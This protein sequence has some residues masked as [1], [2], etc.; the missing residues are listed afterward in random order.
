[1]GEEGGTSLKEVSMRVFITGGSG[2]MGSY[3]AKY[4]IDK[5]FYVKI[6]DVKEPDFDADF[7]KGDVS[8]KDLIFSETEGIDVLFHLADTFCP[9]PYTALEKDI[10]GTI[11]VCEACLKNRIKKVIFTSA[12]RVYGRPKY[13]P[14]DENHPIAPELSGRPLFSVVKLANEHIFLHYFH[15]HGRPVTIFRFYWSFGDRIGGKVLRNMIAAARE[16]RVIKVPDGAGGSFLHNEDFVRASILAIESEK[17]SG[18]VYNLA[19]GVF[20]SW[21]MLA[22]IVIKLVGSGRIEKVDRDSWAGDE[23]LGYDRNVGDCWDISVKKI[24][25]EL[26]FSPSFK[27]DELILLLEKSVSKMI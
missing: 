18:K 21:E 20:I 24:K 15:N 4:F 12:T 3:L 13:T 6:L 27:E 1:M 25:D 8:D 16:A 11:N 19:S 5:D 9:D 2:N 22:S 10:R 7:I 14:V 26:G 17:S 23:I